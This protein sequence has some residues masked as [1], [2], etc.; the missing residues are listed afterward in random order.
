MLRLEEDM[1]GFCMKFEGLQNTGQQA[2]R[3]FDG[4]RRR[5]MRL[6]GNVMTQRAV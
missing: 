5:Q 3:C 1:T 6:C 4:S 2:G